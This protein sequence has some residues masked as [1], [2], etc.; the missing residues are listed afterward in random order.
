M[1]YIYFCVV[2]MVPPNPQPRRQCQSS[3][4]GEKYEK[5]SVFN[6]CHVF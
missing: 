5:E 4:P 3:L 1:I 2:K 6:D